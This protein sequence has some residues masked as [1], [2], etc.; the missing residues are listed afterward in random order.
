MRIKLKAGVSLT[1]L[2]P[3]IAIVV[4]IVAA[5]YAAHNAEEM[6]ITSGNDGRHS[7]NSKHY[8]G[9]AIDLRIWPFPEKAQQEAVV[10][11]IQTA[12]N[13]KASNAVGEYDVVLEKTHIHLEYDPK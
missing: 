13:G 12:L 5:I 8:S 10:R 1:K 2:Q 7:T 9:N 3:Q 11:E 6:V 4:P